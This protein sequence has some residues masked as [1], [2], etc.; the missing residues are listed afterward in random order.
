MVVADTVINLGVIAI[1]Y[2]LLA[3]GMNIKYGHTG[4][5]D[6]GH[7]GFYLIGAYTAALLVL[8]PESGGP[9]TIYLFGANLPARIGDLLFFLPAELTGLVGWLVAILVAMALA[10]IVGA[11]VALPTLRLREDYLAITVL[12]VSVIFQRVVQA[13]SWLV[14]GPDA[15]RGIQRPVGELFPLD[16]STVGGAVAFLFIS[17]A[18]WAVCA[19]GLGRALETDPPE[20]PDGA[21][22]DGSGDRRSTFAS[23]LHAVV[24]FGAGRTL[25]E[26]RSAGSADGLSGRIAG[27]GEDQHV[28]SALI[29]GA[30]AGVIGGVLSIA[31]PMGMLVWGAV[32][33]VFTWLVALVWLV[34]FG[35]DFDAV[36][37]LATLGLGA[38]YMLALAPL[39]FISE[40][41]IWLPLTLL[42]FGVVI[43]ATLYLAVNWSRF[44]EKPFRYGTFA[45]L[46]FG[47]I[48]YLPI[49]II[50]AV[51][52]FDLM[53]AANIVFDSAVWMLSFSGSEPTIG[54]SR[55]MLFFFGT[56]LFVALFFMERTVNSPFG[57]VLR[58]VRN[59]EEVVNSLGKDPFMFKI[60]SMALGS[61]L[62]GLAGALAAMYYQVLVF[63]LF[64]PQVTFI[65]LLMMF[66][67]GLANNRAMIIGAFLF[68]AFQTATVELAGFVAPG[69]RENIQAFRFVVMGLLF[70]ALLYYRPQ[71]IMGE[72]GRTEMGGSE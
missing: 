8:P 12:G 32:V 60:Q 22:A 25:S 14:N 65:A 52:G 41:F 44:A 34:R 64:S 27:L 16:G 28:G 69:L 7:V 3:L 15:L 59:D 53:T 45:G 2:A 17:G 43:V 49:Q 46:W 63:T 35:G 10:G 33:S 23:R 40:L 67:G 62:A 31:L 51:F 26:R 42:A 11:L 9:D 13:E 71:G 18:V 58:A 39:Y 66:L 30:V 21:R 37:Y 19:W 29:A 61:A 57:R 72:P 6:F 36:D 38:A 4:L 1:F 55:F 54:Y 68:W 56:L 24:T 47:F 20:V 70:L 5:L 48:W 50:N